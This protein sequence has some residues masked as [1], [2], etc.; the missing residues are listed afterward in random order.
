MADK[1]NF[2]DLLAQAFRNRQAEMRVAMPAKVTSYDFKAQK[3]TVKP[4]INRKYADG[5]IEEYPVINN[6]PMIFPRSGG[7]SLTFPVKIGDTVLLV[8]SDRSIESWAENGGNVNPDD[9][10]MHNINDAIAIPGLI[11]FVAGSAAKNND[12]VLLTYAGAEI[13]IQ[14]DGKINMK[15]PKVTIDA[16]EVYMTGELLVKGNISDLDNERGT[17]QLFRDIYNEH[18]HPENGNFGPTDDPNQKV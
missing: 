8:F 18:V 4:L 11:P 17:F 12:D 6:V 13:S 9:N 10:R 3:A 1:D 7:A 5:R 14:S 15:S 16:P 2:T